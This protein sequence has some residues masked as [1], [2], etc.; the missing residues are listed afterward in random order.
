MVNP[1]DYGDAAEDLGLKEGKLKQWLRKVWGR[2][3]R[4]LRRH[5]I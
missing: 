3:D 4:F 1:R 5:R 2:V